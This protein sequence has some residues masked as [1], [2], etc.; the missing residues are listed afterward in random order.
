MPESQN[1]FEI[2]ELLQEQFDGA[3]ELS[4]WASDRFSISGLYESEDGLVKIPM[5]VGSSDRSFEA[6]EVEVT[7]ND[8][9]R[10]IAE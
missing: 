4:S 10:K 3:R 7:V 9:I 8:R 6:L 1:V 5:R 2:S